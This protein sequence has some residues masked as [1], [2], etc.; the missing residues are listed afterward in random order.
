[1]NPHIYSIQICVTVL[2]SK[3]LWETDSKNISQLQSVQGVNKRL[4]AE[5]W[6]VISVQWT[7]IWLSYNGFSLTHLR[8]SNWKS[9]V[10]LVLAG[11]VSQARVSWLSGDPHLPIGIR[12]LSKHPYIRSSV[13]SAVFTLLNSKLPSSIPN[14]S[15][16]SQDPAF[17][18]SFESDNSKMC[19]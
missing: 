6:R 8:S 3:S 18:F 1:M 17:W 16:I 10:A 15:S 2:S 4:E 7:L 14:S 19:T 13:S 9:S 5:L 11:H 12:H